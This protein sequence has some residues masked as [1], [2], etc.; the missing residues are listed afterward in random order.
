MGIKESSSKDN[1][2]ILVMVLLIAG[3][4]FGFFLGKIYARWQ[5]ATMQCFTKDK[6]TTICEDCLA[7]NPPLDNFSVN[8][9]IGGYGD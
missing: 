7:N 3:M 5:M 4:V 8:I 6:L 1:R 2:L 9:P